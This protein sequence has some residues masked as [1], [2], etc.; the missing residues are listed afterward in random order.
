MKQ[1]LLC[2][3][4]V[5]A[6]AETGPGWNT[7]RGP[8]GSGVFEAKNLPS[9]IG[10]GKNLLWRTST[11]PGYSSPVIGG[12]HIFL[13]AHENGKIYTIALHRDTGKEAWRKEAPRAKTT[14]RSVNTPVSATPVTDGENVFVFFED[15]GVFSYGPDGQERWRYLASNYNN[16]YGVSASPVLAG[17]KLIVACDQDTD[18]FLMA[19]DAAT[20]KL[21]WK[22]ERTEFTHGF[23]TP[24]I[25]QPKSGP[26][27]VIVSGAYQLA[28]YSVES[29]EKLWWVWGMAW[30]AKSTPVLSGDVL[31]VHSWMAS[32][33]ELGAQKDDVAP[34]DE[35]LKKFDADHDGKLSRDESPDPA[36]K[37]VWF[38]LDLNKD[39]FVDAQEWEVHRKRGQAKNGL[40]AIRLGG[41]GDV[42]ATHV[43]WRFDKSLP[44]IPSPVLYEGVLYVLKEGGVL[45]ALEPA[46][47]RVSK[48]GRI[49]GALEGYFASPVAADGKI[50]TASKEGKVAAVKAGADWQVLHVS[51]LGDEIWATPALDANRLYIRTEKAVYCFGK[52]PD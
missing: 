12:K 52:A 7:F 24:V 14:K 37:P 32:M 42:S 5:A 31:F 50:F 36:L 4:A 28:G 16:P 40:Y 27:Q 51:D 35:V 39:N 44:N 3:L 45:T 48:Q 2:L 1:L 18:S 21:S 20:G 10:P 34:F 38:L 17:G 29:G 23:S 26:A 9:E 33:S 30:Q 13:T 41:K 6:S 11:P 47:G 15:A 25:Y 19:L 8:N 43:L 46:T 22:A 49:T